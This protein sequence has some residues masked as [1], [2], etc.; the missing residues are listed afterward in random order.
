[1]STAAIPST[2]STYRVPDVLDHIT[3][4]K[5]RKHI[6]DIREKGAIF[7][8]GWWIRYPELNNIKMKDLK[9]EVRLQEIN[10]RGTTNLTPLII[11]ITTIALFCLA[12][13]IIGIY[14]IYHPPTIFWG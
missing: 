9:L 14:L 13:L 12:G 10:A 8:Y 4:K 7:G 1:M 11:I 3:D 5:H 6:I 2:P